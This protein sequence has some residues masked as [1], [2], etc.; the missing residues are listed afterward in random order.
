MSLRQESLP[1]ASLP[2]PL[3]ALEGYL[4]R[5]LVLDGEKVAYA[6]IFALAVL[7]RFWDLGARV[8]SHDES[9]HTRYSWNLFHGDGFAHT[10]LMHGPLLFHM[11]ALSYLLF[12]D[13][14]FT[15]RIYPAV[16][17]IIV[18][19]LP[20]FARRWLGRTGAI[21]ASVGFLISPLILYYSRYIREDMPALL[22]ALIMA[23]SIWR[24]IEQRRFRALLWLTFGF[25]ILYATKEV[26]FIYVAIFGSFL[27]LYFVTRML[28]AEWSN[29]TARL[30]FA[31]S[32]LA[33]LLLVLAF[34]GLL[35]AKEMGLATPVSGTITAP[36]LEPTLTASEAPI[37][38]PR[39]SLDLPIGVVGAA[40]GVSVMVVTISGLVGQW[41][42][43][44]RFP[45]LDVMIVLGTLIL[46]MLTPFVIHLFGFNPMDETPRGIQIS[47]AFTAPMVLLSVA[48]GLAWGLK[49]PAPRK[50]LMPA[51]TLT[52]RDLDAAEPPP[53]GSDRVLVEVQP[54]LIDWL[55]AL[56]SSRWWAIG[57]LFWLFFFFFFTTM[58]TNGAGLG[59]GIIGSLAYWLEQ[60]EVR[61]GNQPWYYY[62]L[63]MLPIYEFLPVI[64][65]AAAGVI[66]LRRWLGGPDRPSPS[67]SSA[68][69]S[70]EAEETPYPRRHVLDLDAPVAFPVLL[71]TGYWAVLN[72]VAYSIAGEKMPWLTT[73]LTAP[74]ILIGGWVVG[75]LIDH[76]DWQALTRHYAWMILILLPV[77]ALSFLRVTAPLCTVGLNQ[78]PAEPA[79]QTTYQAL[80]PEPTVGQVLVGILRLPCHSIIPPRYQQGIFASPTLSDQYATYAWLTAL[81]VLIATVAMMITFGRGLRFEQI[82]R[83][84]ALWLVAWLT[85]LT[86]RAAWLAAYI[87]YDN[88]K[89][90]LVYAHSAGAVKEVLAQ[91]EEIS[92]KTTDGYGLRV[93]YDNRVSWPYTWYL[94]NY[95][96]AIY[97][98]NQPSR[99]LIG[100][101]PV[102]L[103]GPDNW[104]KVEPLLG[105]RYYTFE[106]I[107]MWWPMQDYFDLDR[108]DFIN[109]ATDP[110]LQRGVWEIFYR[111]DYDAYADAVQR[112]RGTRPN[113]ELSAWPVAERMRFYIRKDVFAQ[114][115][116]YGVAASEIARATDPYAEGE[117]QMTPSLT[118]GAGI[119]NRP[120]GLSIG[121]DSLLYVADSGNHRIVVFSPEGAFI[122]SFGTYGLAPQPDVLNEPWDVTVAL[123]GT[124]YV[125][126]TWN[127]RIV[128]YTSQG[129]YVRN[130]GFEAPAQDEPIGFWGPRGITVDQQ[131]NLYLAD[132]GNKRIQVFDPQGFF[133]RRIG[134]GGSQEGQLD[135]P[136]GLAIGPDGLLYVADTWNQRISVFTTQGSF[137]RQWYVDAWFAQTNERPFLDVDAQGK[138]Y[139]TDPEAFRVLIFSSTGEYL[140]SF[141]D[142]ATLGLAGA[143][144]VD[145]R[146]HLFVV[147][148]AN[149]TV[150]RYD[151]TDPGTEGQQR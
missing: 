144:A 82:H 29:R 130:W 45:E 14:D 121:P 138:V 59:T 26:S 55:Q 65:S 8:M 38:R 32:V 150:Q 125:A 123:D 24:Y 136:V 63:V 124:V 100:D 39:T 7:T 1:A 83:L 18:V 58:F 47:L 57:A 114:V 20:I 5:L 84:A 112:Y 61:R 62:I 51:S 66:G 109:F 107:R 74:L 85:I 102:I 135:E 42:N 110:A 139:V 88:A 97:Y 23:I 81:I 148:T 28:D 50:V 133:V 35:V 13:N 127:H 116:D 34:L 48:V 141:G 73:H 147:D 113:F 53:G 122:N 37:A 146:G 140:Y 104:S 71:F 79:D 30:V 68:G 27:T 54:D 36:P 129:E 99:G 64:L 151:L 16:V 142:F 25:A 106:Y 2:R 115:W 75:R 56:L 19:M 119:L 9:L 108:Q 6:A 90:Y 126:D 77:F 33:T 17:G 10:P 87:N 117:R 12:G 78:Q 111:R 95:E 96:N 149:G 86:A 15:A 137:V 92:L 31:I 43:L 120:H 46:P 41:R 105:D 91:I 98:E 134:S 40:I 101:A 11:T 93:A 89:E 72:I 145:N 94:R 3:A 67:A 132:T 128:Q 76:I 21:A 70:G 49:P 60:Q 131:G 143:V 69:G 52:A 103:A 4:T 44:R 118:F 80:L 22:G